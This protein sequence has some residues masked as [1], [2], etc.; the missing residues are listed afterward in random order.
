MH[1]KF[2]ITKRYVLALTIIALLSTLAYFNLDHLINSQYDNGKL[3]NISAKQRMLSQ[4][5]SFYAIYYKMKSM[6]KHLDLM[7]E[8]HKKL[9]SYPMSEKLKKIY[10]EKPILLNDKINRY[11]NEADH[12]Y[13]TR[14]GR[15]LTYLLT[16]SKPLLKDL[17]TVAQVYV[18]NAEN[19]TNNLKKVEFYIYILTL[20]TLIFEALFIFLPIT[21]RIKEEKLKDKV[22][23]EQSKFAALGEMIAIIAHQWRQ[24]LAQLNFNNIFLKKK[25][26]DKE[27]KKEL[28]DNENIIHFMSDTITNFE[29]FYKKSDNTTFNPIVSIE[30]VFKIVDSII[31]LREIKVIKEINSKIFIYGNS[32][33]LAHVILSIIQNSLDAIKLREIKNPFIKITL[34]DS[35]KHIVLSI[36]DNAG[37]IKEEPISKIFQ[38]FISKKKIPSTGI[39]LYMSKLI[40][41]DKFGGYIEAKNSDV[42]AKFTIFLPH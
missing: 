11:L 7:R 36:E 28:E 32:N 6:K 38:P 26:E 30:Q 37:G 24:P 18:K 5:V 8:N 9:L 12:F 22:L 41:E 15:S 31:K 34:Q 42:G 27:I 4:Q 25:V 10:F 20:T 23:Q 40:I 16:H 13:Q 14:S 35:Q 1:G 33:S 39:G 29:D 2:N 17:D 3:I 21:K 19:S